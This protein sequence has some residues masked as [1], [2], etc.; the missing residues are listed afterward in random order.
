M[1]WLPKTVGRILV[2]ELHHKSME[3]FQ[4]IAGSLKISKKILHNIDILLDSSASMSIVSR[5]VLP[6]KVNLIK[7]KMNTWSPM[8]DTFNKIFIMN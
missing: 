1:D 2:P 6:P 3:K 5:D 4:N 7:Q 8:A